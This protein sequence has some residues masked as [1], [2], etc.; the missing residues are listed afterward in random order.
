[1]DDDY[2]SAGVT[3]S[4]VQALAKVHSLKVIAART[5]PSGSTHVAQKLPSELKVDAWLE[6]AVARSEDRVRV[7]VRMIHTST[8]E[9][10]WVATYE[11][12]ITDILEVQT[13]IA[14]TIAAELELKLRSSEGRRHPK[15][16]VDPRAQEAYLR[17]RFHWSIRSPESLKASFPYYQ[18]VLELDPN[19][20]LAHSG[21]EEWYIDAALSRILPSGEA[22]M[23]AKEAAA[24]ALQIDPT[25]ADAHSCLGAVL[26]F[27]WELRAARDEFER[28]LQLN[29]NLADAH[30]RLARLLSYLGNM[31]HAVEHIT[32]AQQLDPMSPFVQL[33]VT[34][35]FYVARQFERAI[36]EGERTLQLMSGSSKALD[37]IGLSRHF[38]RDSNRAIELLNRSSARQPEHASPVVGLAYVL[39][40]IGRRTEALALADGLKDRATRAEVSPY[41]FAELYAGLGE[42][43]IALDYLDRSWELHVPE[44]VGIRCDPMFDPLRGE[45]RFRELLVKLNLV[46]QA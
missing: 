46:G 27:E 22:M 30:V 34:G 9:H 6:G 29:S 11:R 14:E 38:L 19:H 36:R 13:D 33:N 12:R 17:A 15:R 2:L 37:L 8:R 41:D 35:T 24:K 44:L 32:V 23:K 10:L 26:L 39:A 18:A 4:L 25:L 45:A 16:I 1:H 21:L 7:S 31:A 3:E 42:A 43:R 5:A 20:P 40:Q 28:A